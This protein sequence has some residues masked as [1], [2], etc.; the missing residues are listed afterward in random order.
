MFQ[1]MD[2][3]YLLKSGQCIY[4][5]PAK[6]IVKYMEELSIVVDYR[7]NPA[8]FVMLEISTLKECQGYESPLNPYHYE[9]KR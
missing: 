8:D 7:M 6:D 9:Q 1:T 4:N 3:L 2:K 5:G